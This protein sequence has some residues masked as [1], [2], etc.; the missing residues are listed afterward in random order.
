MFIEDKDIVKN[1]HLLYTNVSH[2]YIE[3]HFFSS[4]L[5]KSFIFA[6]I[7]DWGALIKRAEIILIE[8]A[9]GNAGEGIAEKT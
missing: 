7:S 3:K 8:P 1:S 4:N 9:P 2:L 6:L 5:F